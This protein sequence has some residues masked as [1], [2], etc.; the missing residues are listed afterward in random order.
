MDFKLLGSGWVQKQPLLQ[1][2]GTSWNWRWAAI[3]AHSS[4]DSQTQRVQIEF[5]YFHQHPSSLRRQTKI[6]A[7]DYKNHGKRIPL[8]QVTIISSDGESK[9][10]EDVIAFRVSSDTTS[11]KTVFS[12]RTLHKKARRDH[13][14]KTE[15]SVE[16]E[17]W[18]RRFDCMREK[19]ALELCS[20]LASDDESIN[21]DAVGSKKQ[22]EFAQ[23]F[24]KIRSAKGVS[25]SQVEHNVHAKKLRDNTCNKVMGMCKFCDSL[26]QIVAN[27]RNQFCQSIDSEEWLLSS[28]M[29]SKDGV[30]DGVELSTKSL[31]SS[32]CG[33]KVELDLVGKAG[34]EGE[35]FDFLAAALTKGGLLDPL[36][37]GVEICRLEDSLTTVRY[38]HVK[39]F[40]RFRKSLYLLSSPFLLNLESDTA[41]TF[42]ILFNGIQCEDIIQVL[43]DCWCDCISSSDLKP[44]EVT[45]DL[46]ELSPS[47]ILV[48]PTDRGDCRISFVL[49]FNVSSFATRK[50]L[51][52]YM[53]TA[54]FRRITFEYVQI[55]VDAYHEAGLCPRRN[56]GSS[57]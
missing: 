29:K 40:N 26:L 27:N 7:L 52:G 53:K 10:L 22:A 17:R 32:M 51:Q 13:L 38:A 34:T 6:S 56:E 5:V 55:L 31:S 43:P 44:A 11:M 18:T 54:H 9:I 48:R 19:N 33:L 16:L 39:I 15:S 35:V 50:L 4:T 28:R 3:V 36:P 57:S 12:L 47:G 23:F 49:S 37:Q 21:V 42:G 20:Q 46:I 30:G 45:S 14:F 25:G 24:T 2:A 8:R 41:R 1:L